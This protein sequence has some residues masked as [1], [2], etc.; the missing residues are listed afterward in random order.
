MHRASWI[1]SAKMSL[2]I[3][4][5][6]V[7]VKDESHEYADHSLALMVSEIQTATNVGATISPATKTLRTLHFPAELACFSSEIAEKKI[8]VLGNVSHAYFLRP[9]SKFPKKNYEKDKRILLEFFLLE[10]ELRMPAAIESWFIRELRLR[11]LDEDKYLTVL[12]V[13]AQYT[14]N[15][16]VPTEINVGINVYE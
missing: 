6:G 1:S 2:Y 14:S 4:A 11:E 10:E 3:L 7:V 15:V 5:P 12:S 9:G 13:W 16:I 8:R